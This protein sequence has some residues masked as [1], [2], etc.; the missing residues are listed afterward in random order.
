MAKDQRRA[1]G[2]A[3]LVAVILATGIALSLVFMTAAAL[4]IVVISNGQPTTLGE[5]TTQVLTGWGGGML[6]V[7]G[8]FVGYAF[9][10]RSQVDP[11]KD[12]KAGGPIKEPVPQRYPR[13]VPDPPKPPT[14]P[15]PPQQA[16]EPPKPP[17]TSHAAPERPQYPRPGPERPDGS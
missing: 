9:G 8:A 3:T 12:V 11:T 4:Y 7:L 17:P 13:P 16:P 15:P 2:P 10:D 6:G 14:A 5:N 1:P